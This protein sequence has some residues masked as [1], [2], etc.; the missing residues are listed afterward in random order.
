MTFDAVFG[1]LAPNIIALFTD[2]LARV[3]RTV[4]TVSDSTGATSFGTSNASVRMSPPQPIDFKLV[5]GD[6]VLATDMT[7]YIAAQD[8]A[9]AS[10]NYATGNGVHFSIQYRA[11][12]YRVVAFRVYPG[13][14]SD[15]LIEVQ[16]RS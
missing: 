7:A 12:E 4:H 14:D 8:L 15:A 11:R 9:D 6:S 2:E 13:G 5:N 1:A 16:L 10:F 3:T